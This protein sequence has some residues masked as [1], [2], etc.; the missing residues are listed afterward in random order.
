MDDRCGESHGDHVPSSVET[1]Q[2]S[3]DA[4]NLRAFLAGEKA[5]FLVSQLAQHKH[6][7]VSRN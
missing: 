1:A 6:K 4:R 5:V 2:L 7:A 3:Q